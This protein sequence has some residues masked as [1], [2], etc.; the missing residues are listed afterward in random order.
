MAIFNCYVSSPEGNRGLI[1]VDLNPC[2]KICPLTCLRT[3]GTNVLAAL[4]IALCF[5]YLY[6]TKRTQGTMEKMRQSP[7]LIHSLW[8]PTLEMY[9]ISVRFPFLHSYKF[10]YQSPNQQGPICP[11]GWNNCLITGR[12]GFTPTL[13][14]P[15]LNQ[16]RCPSFICVSLLWGTPKPNKQKGPGD[17]PA[18]P[19][20]Q[21]VT[22]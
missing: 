5:Q 1:W 8:F 9:P 14:K 11:L 10:A 6:T 19:C 2:V 21:L 18:L 22:G 7:G 4:A 16:G 13:C 20:H 12:A 3:W 15:A 17:T